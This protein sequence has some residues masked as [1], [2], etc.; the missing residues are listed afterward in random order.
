LPDNI[1]PYVKQG[2]QNHR[3]GIVFEEFGW[4]INT[5]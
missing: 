5:L 4:Q 1:I 2:I 3:S